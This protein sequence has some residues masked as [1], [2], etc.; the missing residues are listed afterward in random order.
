[1]GNGSM[2]RNV[3]FDMGRVLFT[4]EPEKFVRKYCP[5]EEDAELVNRE[6]FGAQEWELTDRGTMTE[7]EYLSL[8]LGRVPQRLHKITRWLYE[9]WDEMPQ[10][11]PEMEKLVCALKS[12]GY[13]IYLLSNMSPRFYRF[14]RRIPAMKYFDG[15]IVSSDVRQLKPE[16]EIYRSLYERFSLKP[17]ECFFIDD[18][19][20]NIQ[21]GKT[22]GMNGFIFEQDVE[23]LKDALRRENIK[24]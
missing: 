9:H 17:E 3:V 14:Y 10:P 16:P 15:M 2:I 22:F 5:K 4:Y 6:L 11:L 18:R 23:A 12:N 20:D 7:D 1:M 21:T 24:I 19:E 13:G 8:V